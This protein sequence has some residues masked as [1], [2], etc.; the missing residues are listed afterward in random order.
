MRKVRSMARGLRSGI[1]ELPKKSST[2]ATGYKEGRM[3]MVLL[4]VNLE[5]SFAEANSLQTIR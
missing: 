5:C 3:A 1:R 4:G 2:V